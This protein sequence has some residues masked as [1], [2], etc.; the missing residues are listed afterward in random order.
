MKDKKER[1]L[2]VLRCYFSELDKREKYWPEINKLNEE[3]LKNFMKK[4]N[5]FKIILKYECY[6]YKKYWK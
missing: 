6:N 4:N 5:D 3:H 2:D 1:L